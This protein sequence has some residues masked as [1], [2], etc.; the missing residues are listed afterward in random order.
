MK[1]HLFNPAPRIGFAWD[2][3]GDGKTA[4]R[5]GYGVFFEHTNGNEANVESLES[6]TNPNSTTT[7]TTAVIGYSNILPPAAGA[8]S[9]FSATSVPDKAVWPY[10]QQWHLDVQRDI[11][12]N[13]IAT[14]SYVGSKGTH[15]TRFLDLNQIHR[16]PLSQDPY[17][18]GE[19]A[20]VAD[21][22]NTFDPTWL[23]PTNAHTP[24][25]API[26]YIPGAGGAPGTGPAVN[27]ALATACAGPNGPA[28]TDFFR[29]FPGVGGISRLEETSSSIY[30][31]LEASVRRSVGGLQLT[32]SYTLS[33]SI[34]DSSSARDMRVMDTYNLGSARASSN[35]DQR[36]L[37]SL[38]YVYDLPFFKNPGLSKA[39]LGGWQFSGI[40][41][42]ESGSP[43]SVVNTV[44]GGDNAGV[45]N[46]VASVSFPDLVGNPKASVQNGG[47]IPGFGPLL[48]NPSAFAAPQG[49]TFGTTP[50]NYLRNPR[51][52]NFDMALF[53]RFAINERTSFEFRAEGFNVF[54]H[55]QWLWLGGDAGSAAANA[56]SAN[57]TIGA[58]GTDP[59]QTTYLRPNGAHNPRILQLGAKFIF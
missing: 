48:Y 24:S 32:L 44:P 17:Q 12:R 25:G 36:H 18:P 2:P 15:L 28:L 10:I 40:T 49:L 55:T 37:F 53:K 13:T 57:N 58:Y 41:S 26:P 29:P 45:S 38:G 30:H 8:T 19:A 51:R 31:G 20:S 56:G 27:L 7:T 59:T 39:L 23:V 9:P 35:F 11:T 3:F 42:I 22:G 14:V 33:H 4:I 46:A 5:G 50:R 21:C 47:Q 54:N 43:F 1:G 52:T 16:T 34:D 6:A